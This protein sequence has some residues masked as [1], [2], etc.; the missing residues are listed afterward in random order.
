LEIGE[1]N[2]Q[3]KHILP[4]GKITK[5]DAYHIFS[6]E[7]FLLLL[8]S[9]PHSN[10]G[11]RRALSIVVFHK[12]RQA[13]RSANGPTLRTNAA[14][15]FLSAPLFIDGPGSAGP[16][17]YRRIPTMIRPPINQANG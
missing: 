7:P 16:K 5:C 8:G 3:A 2:L 17:E 11:G 13:S 10:R 6:G 14:F 4:Q 15:S 1:T 9:Y 12:N